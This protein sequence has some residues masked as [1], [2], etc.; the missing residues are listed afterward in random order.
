MQSRPTTCPINLVNQ[1]QAAIPQHF[2]SKMVDCQDIRHP[3][4]YNPYFPQ[5]RILSNS[6]KM[7]SQSTIQEI[8]SAIGYQ[9]LSECGILEALTAA[10]ADSNNFDGNKRLA[11]MGV[12]LIEFHLIEMGYRTNFNR[13]RIF[14]DQKDKLLTLKSKSRSHSINSDD[15]GLSSIDSQA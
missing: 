8:R 11:Q 5:E 15:I 14:P 4:L 13:G 3:V 12:S 7:S 6:S 2:G 1:S 10:G 9:N